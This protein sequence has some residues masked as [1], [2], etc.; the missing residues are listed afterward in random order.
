M[1]CSIAFSAGEASGDL[2]GAFLAAELK[3]LR[4]N[5]RLW[6]AGGPQMRDAG[7]DVTVDMTGGGAIGISESIKALPSIAVHYFQLR[8]Q[9]LERRPDIFVPIDYGA[10][11]VRLAQVA[12]KNGIPVVYDFPPSS[13]RKRPRNAPTLLACGGKVITP[14]PWSAEF[15]TSKGLD[16]RFVGHPLI[17]I[18]KPAQDR[19][20]FLKELEL[21]DRLPVIG[22]LPGSRS[23]ELNEHLGPMIGCAE[24]HAQGAGRRSVCLWRRGAG[25]VDSGEGPAGLACQR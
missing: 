23:H 17:D 1:E 16:A 2:N 15:L 11:N 14:F 8:R 6:G 9:L 25:G 24:D 3:K 5:V 22:L 4:G 19:E 21:S 10:F 7:V 20:T 12:H 13:W 18:V